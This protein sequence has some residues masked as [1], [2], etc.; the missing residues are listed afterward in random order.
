MM[1]EEQKEQER[2][3]EEKVGEEEEPDLVYPRDDEDLLRRV[4]GEVLRFHEAQ[5]TLS[6]V[7][8]V[9]TAVRHIAAEVRELMALRCVPLRRIDLAEM[10]R[11]H[12]SG[13]S[14]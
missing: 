7:E 8:D 3:E 10:T 4:T 13:E 5:G 9:V 1:E 11:R 6:E 12:L 14:D 2:L